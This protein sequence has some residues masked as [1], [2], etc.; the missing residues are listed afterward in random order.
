MRTQRPRPRPQKLS[1]LQFGCDPIIE[2]GTI[3]PIFVVRRL[4][5]K[6]QQLFVHSNKS[7]S[8]PCRVIHLDRLPRL[9]MFWIP[10]IVTRTIKRQHT[11]LVHFDV[12]GVRITAL[13]VAIRH[14]HL[15]LLATNNCNEASD[16]FIHVGH[17]ETRWIV[18]RRRINHA[19]VAIAKHLH[20]M[21]AN[22]FCSS[23]KFAWS[24]LLEQL[25]FSRSIKSMKWLS[26]FF[27]CWII[28]I[29]LFA[30]SA[31][32]Q[33]SAHALRVV[34]RHCWCAF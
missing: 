32:H 10:L 3:K 29:A 8:R 18:V 14:E 12:I 26:N 6:S 28:Y 5:A 1:N 20:M 30:P 17:M 19:G 31:T 33:H 9:T 34:P 24:E 11:D 25:F 16:C 23:I 2:I 4:A 15:W 7:L 21:E 27:E 22:Y 13:I